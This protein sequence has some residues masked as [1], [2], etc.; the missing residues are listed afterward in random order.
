[1]N[2]IKVKLWTVFYRREKG[3]NNKFPFTIRLIFIAALLML[4]AGLLTTTNVQSADTVTLPTL[5]L[6]KN[7]IINN[8]GTATTGDFQAYIDG[9]PVDW[10]SPQELS[11]GIEYT[12]SEDTLPGYSDSVWGGDCAEDGTITLGLYQPATCTITNDDIPP[13]LTL[14]KIVNNDNGGTA[15]ATDWTLTATG[16]TTIFGPGGVASGP[17]FVAGTYT[18][19][20]SKVAGYS[21]TSLTCDDN[22]G[23]QVTSVT[24]GL[25]ETITCTF[26]N[27]DVGF[28]ITPTSGLLTSESGV[29]TA[30]FTVVLDTLPTD[31]VTLSLASSNTDE[32]TIDKSSLLFTPSNWDSSQQVTVTGVEDDGVADGDQPYTIVTGPV[33]NTTD[34]DYLSLNPG[35]IIPDISVINSDNDTPGFT[36]TPTTDLWVSEGGKTETIQVLLKSKPTSQV[37]LSVQSSDTLEEEGV[38]TIQNAVVNPLPWPQT[39]PTEITVTGVDDCESG[40]G[41]LTLTINATSSDTNYNGTVAVLPV[42]NYDAPTI[43]WVKPVETGE[44]YD[45]DGFSPI[46]LKVESLCPEPIQKVRF[47]RWVEALGA[48]VTIGEDLTPPYQEVLLPI[49]LQAEYNQI[50]AFAFSPSDPQTFSKHK[51]IFI[52]MGF[53]NV[54]HLPVV[55]K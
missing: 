46:N 21:L 15:V 40:G 30:T 16:P 3:M 25:G 28:N 51:Y 48:N 24:I 2:L 36:V 19:T 29:P 5:K 34:A 41:S 18:L 42:T 31:D 22:P 9:N 27:D 4:C 49:E 8:G 45:S 44:T 38:V 7:V 26:V 55:N 17:T 52:Y 6:V 14:V 39:T 12:A 35:T 53:N 33:I 23:V 54:I 11:A 13:S 37:T 50:S 20:E 47:Y 32:G 43:G 10:D 1:M